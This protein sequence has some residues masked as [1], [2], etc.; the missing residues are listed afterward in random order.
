MSYDRVLEGVAGPT[1]LRSKCRKKICKILVKQH[2]NECFYCTRSFEEVDGGEER[3]RTL[4]HLTPLSRGGTHF[5]TNLVLCCTKCNNAKG[6]MTLDE[7]TS[8]EDYEKR[9]AWQVRLRSKPPKQRIR[10]EVIRDLAVA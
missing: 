9:R 3:L 4:D 6:N 2:G 5:I 8:S 10:I 1:R 7:Y